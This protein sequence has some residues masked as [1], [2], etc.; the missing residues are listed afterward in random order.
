MKKNEE[1][2]FLFFLA[3]KALSRVKKLIHIKKPSLP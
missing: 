2:A 3:K 1:H